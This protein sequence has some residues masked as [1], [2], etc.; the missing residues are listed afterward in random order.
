VDQH[1]PT[2]PAHREPERSRRARNIRRVGIVA[3]TIFVLAG[4]LGY[5]GPRSSAVSASGGGYQLD[6]RYAQVTRSGLVAPLRVRVLHAG[7]FDEPITLAFS[8]DIFDRFDFQNWYPNPSAETAG[9]LRLEYEFDPPS[10]D[11]FELTLDVRVG[12]T[13]P[14]SAHRYWVAVVSDDNEVARVNFRMVV[15]P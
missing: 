15:M 13:Q 11:A 8:K 7:G 6:V 12:P 3:L 5:F 2:L 14:P 9:P 10:G 1:I 4:L